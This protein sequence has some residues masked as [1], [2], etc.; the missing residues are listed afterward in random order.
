MLEKSFDHYNLSSTI[1]DF[2]PFYFSANLIK[3]NPLGKNENRIIC[4]NSE[5]LYNIGD[6]KIFKLHKNFNLYEKAK[7]SI[8]VSEIIAVSFSVYTTEIVLHILNSYD[9]HFDLKGEKNNF[10]YVIANIYKQNTNSE[11]LIL[12][13]ELNTLEKLCTTIHRIKKYSA[14]V[15]RNFLDLNLN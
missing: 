1:A 2:G 8:R 12:E 6:P 4:I 13:R 11:L 10:L 15:N 5:N 14:T 9:Y 3:I 7:R